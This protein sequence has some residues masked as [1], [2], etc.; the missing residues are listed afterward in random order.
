[1]ASSSKKKT[2]MAKIMRENRLRERRLDKQAKKDARKQAAAEPPDG[3]SA[4]AR[5]GEAAL[6]PAV[7][8]PATG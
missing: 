1:M 3:D 7:Q 6:E 4:P 2:T 8:A 5:V